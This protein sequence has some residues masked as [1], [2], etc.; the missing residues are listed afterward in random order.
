MLRTGFGYPGFAQIFDGRETWASGVG[1]DAATLDEAPKRT[2]PSAGLDDSGGG[3][4]EAAT[5]HAKTNRATEYMTAPKTARR[6][7]VGS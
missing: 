7:H 4:V 2:S 5:G 3:A 6:N 1:I